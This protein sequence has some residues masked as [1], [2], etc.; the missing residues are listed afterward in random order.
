MTI[1]DLNDLESVGESTQVNFRVKVDLFCLRGPALVWFFRN[2]QTNVGTS[3][4]AHI[5]RMIK[6]ISK[7]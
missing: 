1:S 6:D 7:N 2:F 4:Y 5:I 3:R